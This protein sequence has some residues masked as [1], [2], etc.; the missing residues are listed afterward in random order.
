MK[1][2]ARPSVSSHQYDDT[3]ITIFGDIH[4][5]SH[6]PRSQS[7]LE[8]YMDGHDV[9]SW[10]ALGYDPDTQFAEFDRFIYRRLSD[11]HDLLDTSTATDVGRYTAAVNELA[12][13]RYD[14]GWGPDSF[15]STPYAAGVAAPFLVLANMG[16]DAAQI[17]RDAEARDRLK[18]EF[19]AMYDDVT[20]ADTDV[21][22]DLSVTPSRRQM[23]GYLAAPLALAWTG[24][25]HGIGAGIDAQEIE[26]GVYTDM[27]D[28]FTAEGLS[29]LAEHEEGDVFHLC[30][31]EHVDGI[32]TYLADPAER[33]NR[34][35]MYGPVLEEVLEADTR[36]GRAVAASGSWWRQDAVDLYP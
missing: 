19:R 6:L 8:T 31:K 33:R 22:L 7:D 30:G 36:M 15:H 29:Y 17:A 27:R 3:K 12:F 14:E 32:T 23:I 21:D 20:G 5:I 10:E 4:D 24:D 25:L 28:V 34:L 9:F 16:Y 1:P 26:Y 35:N 18:E 13:D 11:G 2:V